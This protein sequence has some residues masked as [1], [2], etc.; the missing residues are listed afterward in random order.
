MARSN[1][2]KS[3]GTRIENKFFSFVIHLLSV[4]VD[5]I[6]L[7]DEQNYIMRM[8]LM[9]IIVAMMMMMITANVSVWWL[10]IE[11]Q[12]VLTLIL[13]PVLRKWIRN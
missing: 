13:N 1:K 6:S 5:N 8:L 9:M 4:T 7:S 2:N 12:Q 10:A 11:W 3:Q